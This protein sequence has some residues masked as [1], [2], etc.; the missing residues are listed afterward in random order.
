MTE[1][2]III[3]GAGISGL[4]TGCY[5]Q[6]NGYRT[7][8]FELH[9]L[10]GGLCTAWK[11]KKYTFDGCIHWLIGA[12]PDSGFHHVWEELGAVQGRSMVYHH[13]FIRFRSPNGKALAVYTDIDRLE[14]HMKALFPVDAGPIEEYTQAARHFTRFDL[15]A[16]PILTPWE[17]IRVLP[18]AGSLLK[19]GRIT[20]QDFAARFRD[21]FLRQVFPLIHNYPP[22]PMAGHLANLASWHSQNSGWPTGGSLPFAL[23][24]QRRYCDLGG[25]IHY[26]SRVEKV[27]VEAGP[28]HGRGTDRAVG[29][30]LADGTEHY[31]DVVISAADGYTTIFDMLGGEY[32]NDQIRDYYA[33]PPSRQ[34]HGIL[35]SLGVSRDLA[36]EPHAVT[37]LLEQP[38]TIAGQERERLTV[39]HYSFDPTMAP[40]G[41]SAIGVWLESSYAY[42][43]DMHGDTEKYETE[44]QR[45]ANAVI[46]QLERYYPGISGQIEV[47]DV[48]TPL[49]IERYTGNWR[50][51]EAWFPKRSGLGVMLKGL[52]R[53]LPG[54]DDFYMVGQ[55][56]GAAGGLPMAAASGRKLIQA[57]CRSHRRPFLTSLPSD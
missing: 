44:K 50:G 37:Y 38:T 13:E 54:L 33:Q 45:V 14:Q 11:R 28:K 27:L 46:G 29:V 49:T 16:L 31:A 15:F 9:T 57:L 30:R 32:V 21:P 40:A 52:S 10:P 2:S 22:F 3:I 1:K 8:I 19:W 56:A 25:E 24:I 17:T 48:A 42:W 20:M 39:E 53:T 7:Q 4:A 55:W 47:V 34:E 43:Q 6:M 41:K 12:G 23:A 51:S 36:N 35:V 18:F 26:R 5:G